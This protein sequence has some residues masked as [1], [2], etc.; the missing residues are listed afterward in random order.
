MRGLPLPRWGNLRRTTPF[1]TAFGFDRGTPIDRY[2]VDDFLGRHRALIT[3]RVLEIQA[4]GYTQRF[5]QGVTASHTLDIDP[6][7]A[8]TYTCDLSRAQDVVPDNSYDCF[9]LPN[10]LQHLQDID[11]ALDNIHRI[12]RPGGAII[13]TAAAFIP[14]IPDGPDYW[15]ITA[16]GWHEQTSRHWPHDA[17]EIAAY[18]NCLAAIAAMHGLSVEDVTPAELDVHDPRYPV[19]IGI[20]CRKRA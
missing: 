15:R 17:V 3:G 2:Y 13:A 4:S 14:L 20:A 18:G 1:S 12:V 6:K 19:L 7:F 8:A 10:T 16:D 5:G 9:L 11:G